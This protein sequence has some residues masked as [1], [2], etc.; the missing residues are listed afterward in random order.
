MTFVSPNTAY[1]NDRRYSDH[2]TNKTSEADSLRRGSEISKISVTN[3]FDLL[4]SCV[5]QWRSETVLENRAP[6]NNRDVA[7]IMEQAEISSTL[8]SEQGSKY[9]AMQSKRMRRSSNATDVN[10]RIPNVPDA[11]A[12]PKFSTCSVRPS[13]SYPLFRK[14]G[15]SSVLNSSHC[16]TIYF[17]DY[18]D[19]DAPP[20]SPNK[21]PCET[22]EVS[23]EE[24]ERCRLLAKLSGPRISNSELLQ[25]DGTIRRKVSEILLGKATTDI[26]RCSS[27]SAYIRRPRAQKNALVRR[28]S[29]FQ[30][31]RKSFRR[32]RTAKS[33]GCSVNGLNTANSFPNRWFRNL[34]SSIKERSTPRST[35]PVDTPPY[36]KCSKVSERPEHLDRSVKM[37]ISTESYFTAA[38]VLIQIEPEN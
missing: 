3:K 6:I 34:Q 23:E 37:Q 17:E 32:K 7:S 27:I 10:V 5:Q 28:Q 2:K 36:Q 1:I 4:E 16:P 21:F 22:D 20:C 25:A 15:S 18:E 35:P 33:Q 11:Q 38:D 12:T 19:I 26:R 13:Q 14:I 9:A 24:L 29:L 30:S 31:F 8:S